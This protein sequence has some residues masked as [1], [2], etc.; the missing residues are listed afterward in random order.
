[1]E[2]IKKLK[3]VVLSVLPIVAIASILG[4][5][6][7][8][9]IDVSLFQFLLSSLLVVIGLTFFL[10]GVDMAFLPLG[11]QLG[12]K[13]T[14]KKSLSLLLFSGLFLGLIVT[15]AEPDIRVL[16]NQVSLI[17]NSVNSTSFV[18]IVALGVGVFMAISYI[19]TLSGASIKI[20]M[21]LFILLMIA[22]SIFLPEFFVSISYDAGGAT[23]GPLAVPFI[24]ALGMGVA[25][26][27]GNKEEDAFGFTG[28]ASVGPVLAV[29]IYS[30]FVNKESGA[31]I[32][33]NGGE[34][35]F[36]ILLSVVKSVSSSLLPIALLAL[37][38]VFFILRLPP[39]RATKII[40]GLLYSYF[41]IIMF[42]FSVESA[43]MPVA[44]SL[45]GMIARNNPLLL[46][47]LG[48]I[49]GAV[50]VLAEPAI[51]V[52]TEEVEEK[53]QGKIKKKLMMV[54]MALGVAFA[55]TLS[56]V[57]II[58]GIHILFFIIPIYSYILI[59]LPFVPFLFTGIAFDSG[60]VATGPMSSTFLLPLVSGASFV[61]AEN[62]GAMAFGMIGLIAAMPVLAIEILGV[63]YGVKTKKEK[64]V[65]S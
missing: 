61:V 64:G 26:V 2:L 49:L 30:L 11:N 32:I 47:V 27:H 31:V 36:E 3:E 38:S 46:I 34:G 20:F 6:F 50:V 57:R 24:I 55:V 44:R 9:F 45:G 48:F 18:Y 41:G 62:P 25:S 43:F 16:A 17:N 5:V 14:G 33:E 1:M 65:E 51:W 40:I 53:S 23:T 52:L 10:F 60:G 19:R 29:M 28:I 8:S 12:A 35:V 22:I 56:M 4:I 59:L 15:I 13:I 21:A 7:D 39:V 42:L 37:V 58:T 54:F 63:I